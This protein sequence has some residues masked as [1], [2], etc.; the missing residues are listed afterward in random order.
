[1]RKVLR[2]IKK[3]PVSENLLELFY[4][5]IFLETTFHTKP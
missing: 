4:S 3:T 1:L 2:E 5:I